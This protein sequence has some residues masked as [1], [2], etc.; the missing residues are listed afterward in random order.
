MMRIFI[1]GGTG[2]V[3]RALSARLA[4]EGHDVQVLSRSPDKAGHLPEGVAAVVGDPTRPGP[5]QE[6]AAKAEVI[7]NLAGASIFSRWTPEI[8]Q[9]IRDSRILTT[10]NLVAA[11][12]PDRPDGQT[13]INAGAAGYFGFANQEPCPEATPAGDDFLARVCVD[14]EQEAQQAA[15][16]GCRVVITRFAVILDPEG[17]ALNKMLPAFRLGFGGR[18]GHG[19]QWFPWIHLADL[20]EIFLFLLAH[21]KIAGPVNCAA[22]EPARNEEFTRELGRALHRPVLMPVPGWLPRLLLGEM[23]TVLLEGNRMIPK[24]LT[25]NGFLFRFPTIRQALV[26]LVG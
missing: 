15:A 17:G 16:K 22:P 20:L 2:F 13:L 21:P 14:W 26:D 25:N 7:I 12:K 10:R 24:V 6:Q 9:R 8:K 3:G 18:L 19:R 4:A 23:S 11:M 1:V 5:W